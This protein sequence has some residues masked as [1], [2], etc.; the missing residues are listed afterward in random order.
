MRL[1]TVARLIAHL[2]STMPVRA[3]QLAIALTVLR[4]Y[5]AAPPLTIIQISACAVRGVIPNCCATD[6]IASDSSA[7]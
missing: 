3:A 7:Y 5:H 1:W 6:T 4:I 2:A